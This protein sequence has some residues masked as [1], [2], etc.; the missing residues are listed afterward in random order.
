MTTTPVHR[1]AATVA[2]STL[3]WLPVHAGCDPVDGG[4]VEVSWDL[5]TTRGGDTDCDRAGV[6]A[7]RLWWEVKR[8]LPDGGTRVTRRFDEFPCGNARG[9]TVFDL[10]PGEAALWLR[11]VCAGGVEPPESTFRAPAPIVRMITVGEVVTLVT[12]VIEVK[13]T[14]CTPEAPC[15]CAGGELSM[16]AAPAASS[17]SPAVAPHLAANQPSRDT[18]AT[19]HAG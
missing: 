4:A 5:R 1:A 13:V 10:P 19:V 7:I 6:T 17:I 14:D 12:Q 9:V 11:P 15:I 16:N 8:T 18:R 3:A 2:L